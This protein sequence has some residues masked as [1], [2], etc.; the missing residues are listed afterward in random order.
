MKPE[1]NNSYMSQKIIV[2]KS[3]NKL[4][5]FIVLSKIDLIIND[6]ILKSKLLEIVKKIGDEPVE[7]QLK[8]TIKGNPD[9]GRDSQSGK[10][11]RL[12]VSGDTVN[13]AIYTQVHR[14]AWVLSHT[15]TIGK[16]IFDAYVLVLQ[17]DT[18]VTEVEKQKKSPENFTMN[19]GQ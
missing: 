13:I 15:H 8:R 9:E 4:S 2:N 1:E 19:L 7:Y 10:A 16:T 11:L 18:A 6:W 12:S 14:E 5:A 17:S 3:D